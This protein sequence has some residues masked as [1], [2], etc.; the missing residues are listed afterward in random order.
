MFRKDGRGLATYNMYS[1][2]QGYL[3]LREF[4][5]EKLARHRGIQVS[6]NEVLITSGS[7]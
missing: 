4:V 6:T 1:G 2:P 5:A 7:G 3:P